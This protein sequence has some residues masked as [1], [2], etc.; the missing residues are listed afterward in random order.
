MV[1]SSSDEADETYRGAR[2]KGSGSG[3]KRVLRRRVNRL[4]S[5]ALTSDDDSDDNDSPP[6]PERGI[7]VDSGGDDDES[8]YSGDDVR[9]AKMSSLA[10]GGAGAGALKARRRANNRRAR[11][12]DDDAAAADGDS[13]A[14]Y[15]SEAERKRLAEEAEPVP[16]ALINACRV[17]RASLLKHRDEPYFSTMVC[18]IA[19]PLCVGVWNPH[20]RVCG[21]QIRGMFVRVVASQ[22]PRTYAM[23][24]VVRRKQ[25]KSYKVDGN[26]TTTA[27]VCR[28]GSS[29]TDRTFTLFRVSNAPVTQ[30]RSQHTAKHGYTGFALCWLVCLRLRLCLLAAAVAQEE[31]DRYKRVLQRMSVKM[32]TAAAC[33][34]H[35]ERSRNAKRK[36]KYTEDEIA[37]LVAKRQAEI[38]KVANIMQLRFRTEENLRLL[39]QDMMDAKAVGD[40]ELMA[41]LGPK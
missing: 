23:A 24:Q 6:P 36:H 8:D 31:F 5:A 37:R 20:T 4:A 14:G 27:I 12:D 1:Q 35:L 19:A 38:S 18:A 17:S 40:E 3:P 22:S 32:V 41:E 16:L 15:D 13:S 39:R 26:R 28:V 33:R 30:V 34:R 7:T 25:V 29:K 2:G 11:D 10:R 21:D 9:A